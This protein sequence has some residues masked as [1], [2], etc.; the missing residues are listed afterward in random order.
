MDAQTLIILLLI[1]VAAGI[2]GGFIGVG[3]GAVIVPC[4]VFFLGMTQFQAQ[5]TSLAMMLPPIGILAVM[6]YHK[7]GAVDIK[8][9]LVL[10]AAFVIGGYIGSKLALRMD[11]I[12]VKL[13]FGLFLFFVAIRMT[14]KALQE[15][16]Q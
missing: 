12:K 8:Y 16:N 15:L 13:I 3:G 6:N 11:P 14:F 1:G 2:L 4:L 10:A 9:G 7:A 5:G